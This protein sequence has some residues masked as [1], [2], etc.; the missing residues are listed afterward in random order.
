MP[1]RQHQ[2]GRT[3]RAAQTRSALVATARRLFAA[4]GYLATG[5]EQIVAEAGVGTR[6]ALYHHFEDKQDLF[7]AVFESVEG[8]L[9]NALAEQTEEATLD[10]LRAGLHGFLRAAAGD[11]DVQQILL[12][13]G[14]S[15]LGWDQ[16]RALEARYGLGAIRA[17]LEQAI[18]NGTVRATPIEPLAHLLLAVV[19]ESALYVANAA[20]RTA[21]TRDALDALDRLLDGLRPD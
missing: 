19:D 9:V 6:G 8:D 1:E 2:S 13:D 14:P 3:D 21:A 17:Q 16:W 12:L 20:D 15:V 7:R 11:P 5:T 10:S 4:Q 18:G